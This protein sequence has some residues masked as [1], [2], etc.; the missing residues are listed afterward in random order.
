MFTD[1]QAFLNYF[2]GAHKRSVRDIAALPPE[3]ESSQGPVSEFP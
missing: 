2:E 1:I 3:A